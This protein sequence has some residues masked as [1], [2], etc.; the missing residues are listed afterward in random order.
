[1]FFRVLTITQIVYKVSAKYK[2]KNIKTDCKEVFLARINQRR[3]N[4]ISRRNFRLT[5]TRVYRVCLSGSLVWPFKKI[6]IV[7]N[8]MSE[9]TVDKMTIS[10]REIFGFTTNT[11][12]YPLDNKRT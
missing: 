6:V 3:A 9:N 5:A 12:R 7:I 1:L 8:A 10:A 4:T 2:T 11:N